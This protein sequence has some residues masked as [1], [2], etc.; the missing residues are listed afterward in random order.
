MWAEIEHAV[1]LNKWPSSLLDRVHRESLPV[2][3]KL[4]SEFW[5]PDHQGTKFNRISRPKELSLEDFKT[6]EDLN[7]LRSTIISEI[8]VREHRNVSKVYQLQLSLLALVIQSIS[9]PTSRRAIKALQFL[10][11]SGEFLKPYLPAAQEFQTRP[12]N[13][14]QDMERIKKL[15]PLLI[16]TS[17]ELRGNENTNYLVPD[18]PSSDE[19]SPVTSPTINALVRAE[20][21]R[22]SD[23]N[24]LVNRAVKDRVLHEHFGGLY[25]EMNDSP[26]TGYG[27]L[28][29][30]EDPNLQ[31][32]FH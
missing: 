18:L 25:P 10:G 29:L 20:P 17:D 15:R 22:S 5:R 4:N 2:L 9:N 3:A 12:I 32:D 6:L 23:W 14:R 27:V 26:R 24:E 30:F 19:D 21:K 11:G 13:L 8:L 7:S 31:R 16:E 28:A 1:F